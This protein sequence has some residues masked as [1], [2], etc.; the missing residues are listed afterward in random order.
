MK[1]SNFRIRVIDETIHR[2]FLYVPGFCI[3]IIQ[4]LEIIHNDLKYT[5]PS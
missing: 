3:I 5:R 2:C 1:L 4:D